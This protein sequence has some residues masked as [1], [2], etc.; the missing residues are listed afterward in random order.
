VFKA[1]HSPVALA[2]TSDQTTRKAPVYEVLRTI[3]LELSMPDAVR[4]VKYSPVFSLVLKAGFFVMEANICR[5]RRINE[6][7]S[8]EIGRCD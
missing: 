8:Y 2:E 4:I 5:K 7:D 1:L 3:Q 6:K